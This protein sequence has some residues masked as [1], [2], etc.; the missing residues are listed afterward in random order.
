MAFFRF[1]VSMAAAAAALNTSR[2]SHRAGALLSPVEGVTVGLGS[3]AMVRASLVVS[4]LPSA[5]ANSLP[6]AVSY[7][8]LPGA[9]FLHVGV[10][11]GKLPRLVGGR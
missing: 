2:L 6:Q 8:H 4:V 3:L 9:S 5:S 10:A 7:T 11:A 1:R